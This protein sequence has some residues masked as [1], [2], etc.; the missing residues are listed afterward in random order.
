[1]AILQTTEP[2]IK[3]ATTGHLC[4]LPGHK[5]GV[6]ARL[7]KAQAKVLTFSGNQIRN[8]Q[9]FLDPEILGNTLQLSPRDPTVTGW[10]VQAPLM[11][12]GVLIA[13]VLTGSSRQIA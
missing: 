10:P 4:Q 6:I 13:H 3:T 5:L 7:L 11:A 1:M 2:H 9:D 8:I 12:C